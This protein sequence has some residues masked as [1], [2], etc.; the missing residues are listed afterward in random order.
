MTLTSDTV[1]TVTTL[2]RGP[3]IAVAA[4]YVLWDL[5]ERGFAL[6]VREDRLYVTPYDQLTE[7][8][9]AAIRRHRDALVALV[10]YCET[11]Q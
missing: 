2:S 3:T 9:V 10:R 7:A 11:R 8:D 4:L 5:E 6:S 1:G